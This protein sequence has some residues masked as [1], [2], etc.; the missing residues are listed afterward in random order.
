MG[1]VQFTIMHVI[2]SK[3]AIFYYNLIY[4]QSLFN[5]FIVMRFELLICILI[6]RL[7][8]DNEY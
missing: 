1:I 2:S 5:L 6:C 7:Q 8:N 3:Y 4:F